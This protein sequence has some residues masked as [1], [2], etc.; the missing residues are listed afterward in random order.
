MNDCLANFFVQPGTV[1]D[2]FLPRWMAMWVFRMVFCVNCLLQF[3]K[4]HL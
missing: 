1:Q 3:S 4:V 2:T